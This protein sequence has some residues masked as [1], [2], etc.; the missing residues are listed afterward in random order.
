[1]TSFPSVNETPSYATLLNCLSLE[2]RTDP[3]QHMGTSLSW[4]VCCPLLATS[5][6]SGLSL[7]PE[8]MLLVL[9]VLFPFVRKHLEYLFTW[10]YQ[11]LSYFPQWINLYFKRGYS[12]RTQLSPKELTPNDRILGVK[13]GKDIVI[14]VLEALLLVDGVRLEIKP[15]LLVRKNYYESQGSRE[16]GVTQVGAMHKWTNNSSIFHNLSAQL[17]LWWLHF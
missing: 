11:W 4:L 7:L 14:C 17:N 5:S 13:S 9:F 15:I 12:K 6:I 1:M 16:I 3:G 8:L 2:S 10:N